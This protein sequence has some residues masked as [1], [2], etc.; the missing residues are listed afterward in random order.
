MSRAYARAAA[1][2]LS[3]AAV[4]LVW[5]PYWPSAGADRWLIA[6]AILLFALHGLVYVVAEQVYGSVPA[7]IAVVTLGCA[8]SAFRDAGI[9]FADVASTLVY[10]AAVYSLSRNS[11]DPTPQ[12]IV[13]AALACALTALGPI[14]IEG[15]GFLAAAITLARALSPT[16]R[17][18]WLR[19]V[20]GA[21]VATLLAVA[22]GGL[23][24]SGLEH[25]G[26]GIDGAFRCATEMP[27]PLHYAPLLIL[28]VVVLTRPWRKHRRHTDLCSV[29]GVSVL[30][31]LFLGSDEAA[32]RLA[33]Y[34]VWPLLAQL[35]AG[36]FDSATGE[37]RRSLVVGVLVVALIASS[38]LLG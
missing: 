15:L 16:P 27:N 31:W 36:Q 5:L 6:V 12:G 14:G 11:L 37:A 9:V 10:V 32:R 20:H 4:A 33:S 29:G 23:L 25:L 17:E 24:A 34:A 38:G 35:A 30:V 26:P 18:P 3:A 19:S 1:A 22:T 28:L 21:A 7:I 13:L 8:V 2:V